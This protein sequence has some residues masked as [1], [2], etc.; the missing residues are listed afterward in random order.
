MRMKSLLAAV[1]VAGL[2]IGTANAQ[3]LYGSLIGNVT[4]PTNAAIVDAKVTITERQTNQVRE[5]AT[6]ESGLFSFQTLQPGAYDLKVVRDGFRM[7]TN[8]GVTV[9]INSVTRIDVGLQM[10]SVA[11]TVQVTAAATLMQTDRSEVRSEITAEAFQNLP[12]APGRNYQQLFKTLP[13]FRPPTNAHSVPTNPSRALTFN[14]NGASYAINN[15]KIDGASSIAPWLPH[16]TAFVPTL[17]AIETVNVVTNSFD[18]E[19]GLAGGAAVNVQIRSG[20]NDMHVVLFAY[21]TNNNLK[22]KNF[23]L[24]AGQD[25]PKL[26]NNEFGGTV[27]GPIK[28]DKLFYFA[29]YEGSPNREFASRFGSVPTPAMKLGDMSESP[30]I[31]Y[32]PLTGN[33]DGSG[34]VA[35]PDNRIPA[36]RISPI[37]KKLVDLTPNPNQPG[38][39]NNF[40][41][42]GSYVYDRH[43]V[44]SKVNYSASSKLTMFGRYSQMHY[45]MNN[46]Q[47]FGALGGPEISGAGGNP[48]KAN[49]DTYSFTGAA[50]YVFTPTLIMDA[51]F[52]YTRMDTHV[53]QARLDKKLGTDFLG[54]PGT[55][56]SRRFEGGWP[57]FDIDGYTPLGV[58]YNFMPYDRRD[59]QSQYVANFNWTKK[60]HE[61]R[62]GFDLY[63]TGMNHTQ[64]EATGAFYGAQGG[65]AFTGGPTTVP[66]Q[67]ANNFNSYSAFLLGLPQRAGKITQVPD[68][69][70]TRSF[71]YSFYARDRWNVSRKLTLSYGLRWEYFPFPTRA[72]RGLE[73]YDQAAN[74]M[75]ICGIGNIPKNCGVE[76][77][78][79]KFAP[80][81]GFAYRVNEGFVIRAGYGLT[82]DP[83]S[84]QRP[85]R[86]NYPVLL[87]Q[88]LEGANAFQPYAPIA[89]GIPRAVVPDFGNGVV[90]I[91]PT[92]AVVT[93]DKNFKR[94]YVQSW[95]FTIQ[96]QLKWDFVGQAGYVATRSTN[97]MGYLDLNNGQVIGAGQAGRPFRQQFG[98]TAATTVVKPF[99]TTQ[100]DSLQATL[101]RRLARGVGLNMAYTWSKVIG[102]VDNNDGGPAVS[103]IAYFDRNRNVRNYDRTHNVQ[104]SNIIELP[105]G[106]GQKFAT[107]GAAA[108]VLGGWQANSILSFYSGTPFTIGSDGASLN[109][110]GSTQ[111][112]DQVK[113]SVEKFG[114]VGRGTPYFD[115]TA[116]A[117]VTAARFGNTGHNII[118]GPGV[119]NW[120]FSIFRK[121]ALTERFKLEFRAES[122]N[123]TNTPHF[124]NPGTNVS[125]FNPTITDPLRR[126]G[127]F[128][129]ITGTSGIGRDGIDERQFR[130]GLRLNF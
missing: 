60:S 13:G 5:A 52:G 93:A 81:L 46:P 75:L 55:N 83:F 117:P 113:P 35:F 7:Y 30:R 71:Q 119:T 32:D 57:Q 101:S 28:K 26:V 33:P 115:V 109:L 95:N 67:S 107:T 17:E 111:T 45:N 99:G 94:G 64:P 76:E 108:A 89:Q 79:R 84:L 48:G 105:F 1:V 24:P 118:R 65:F 96:K 53:A 78:K 123:F 11:E 120:D 110:P 36:N 20:T 6:N 88:N 9:S 127:G 125:S 43:R 122:F 3:I 44:D 85:F 61:V 114:A 22:A 38:L 25:K 100:Y 62:F 116:F 23:F 27:G 51:Y 80:R 91:P 86:T 39:S 42:G 128:G 49:G 82:N 21:N 126:F 124:N 2:S 63:R 103:A 37:T 90:D 41:Q 56:G 31:V 40:F 104:I 70:N 97:Q 18:A 12:V 58:P 8:T 87:I 54:I 66:S 129:E 72:D 77:S 74:K 10:G 47:L 69:Y 29:S 14:V 92:F 73:L 98:R 34:R 50:T 121:F 16:A 106:K 59:P 68:E 15:T 130:L 4:D 19:Q 102:Y 112:A